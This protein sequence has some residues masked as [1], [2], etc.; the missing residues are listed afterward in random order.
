MGDVNEPKTAGTPAGVWGC[1][2]HETAG[3]QEFPQIWEVIDWA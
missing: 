2:G 3:P 1:G